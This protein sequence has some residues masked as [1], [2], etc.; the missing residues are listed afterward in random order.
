MALFLRTIKHGIYMLL[1]IVVGAVAAH[2]ILTGI[3]RH[4]AR[5]T[6]PSLESLTMAEAEA[7]VAKD[8]FKLIIND[9]LYAPSYRSGAILD[10]LPKAGVVVK[11]GRAIY[12]TV[13]ATQ[14]RVVDVPY[15]ADR[16]L[17]QA[18]NMLDMAGLTIG[19][20][21]YEDDLAKNYILKQYI[22]DKEIKAESTER[23]TIGTEVTLHVGRGDNDSTIVPMVMG[24]TL[25]EAKNALWNAGLNVGRVR[26][27]KG[28]DAA[29][30]M[31]ARIY[32][33]SVRS[34]SDARFGDDISLELS[35]TQ[36]KVDSLI[37]AYYKMLDEER[38]AEEELKLLETED[39]V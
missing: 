39:G 10:Q 34:D 38:K 30:Q 24:L 37:R 23:A 12:L 8:E 15:V 27:D 20:L 25:R 22:E 11:P 16:S 1:I 5:C 33:Q 2:F 28:D 17:R 18:K 29:M 13:N 36:P 32:S 7:I 9:S 19:R 21:I 3:T 14:R 4:D 31:Q 26:F 6:V 35:A